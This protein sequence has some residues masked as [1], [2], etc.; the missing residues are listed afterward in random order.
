MNISKVI[1]STILLSSLL[2]S[3]VYASKQMVFK[4][5]VLP[6]CGIEVDDAMGSVN[7]SDSDTSTSS[8]IFTVQT[9]HQ[10][11]YALVSFS[12]KNKS[13]NITNKDGYFE[14]VDKQNNKTQIDWNNPQSAYGYH[15]EKQE[16]F[17]MVPQESNT[18]LAGTAS[19]TTTLEVRCD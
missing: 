4:T 9:N 13:D 15:D 5:E 12:G 17:A 19:V 3:T 7:F 18:I 1:L 16:V 11:G 6:V 10:D 14:V 2:V 8:A